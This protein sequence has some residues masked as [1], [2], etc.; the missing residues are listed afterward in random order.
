MS[1]T[2]GP[3]LGAVVKVG[4]YLLSYHTPSIYQVRDFALLIGYADDTVTAK[5][6]PDGV[7]PIQLSVNVVSIGDGTL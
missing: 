1:Y 5:H 6:S 7:V 2:T 4:I 3:V